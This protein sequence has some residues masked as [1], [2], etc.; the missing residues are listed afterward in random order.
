MNQKTTIAAIVLATI[1]A[2]STVM[3]ALPWESAEASR[4][5][6]AT[7]GEGG[8]ARSRGGDAE[9]EAEGG[10]ARQGDFEAED[11]GDIFD[12]DAFGGNADGNT[13]TGGAGGEATGGDGG[14]ATGGTGSP[15]AVE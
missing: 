14:A 6:D 1:L 11:G 3:M 9:I 2:A 13:A 7:G 10:D 8:D 12:N 4:G 15:D 5:G